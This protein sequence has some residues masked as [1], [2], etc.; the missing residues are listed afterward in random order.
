MSDRQAIE[1]ATAD[2]AEYDKLIRRL[3]FELERM[4]KQY[5]T[6]VHERDQI[7]TFI[8]MCERYRIGP[9]RPASTSQNE[10]ET[11]EV[12]GGLVGLEPTT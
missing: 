4:Q 7:Q 10:V 9:T 3:N 6:R 1:N 12:V 8:A 2:L 5:D 11:A